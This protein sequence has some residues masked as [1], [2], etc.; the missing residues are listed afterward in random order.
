MKD[1]SNGANETRDGYRYGRIVNGGVDWV[2][3]SKIVGFCHFKEHCGFITKNVLK[4]KACDS[5]DYYRSN[6]TQ[7]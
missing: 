1:I 6:R 4:E 2:A 5:R 3:L 7:K